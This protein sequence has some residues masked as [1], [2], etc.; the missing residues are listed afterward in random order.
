MLHAKKGFYS[1]AIV[2]VIPVEILRNGAMDFI[3]KGKIRRELLQEA[4]GVC[5]HMFQDVRQSRRMMAKPT[6]LFA[7]VQG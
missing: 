6:F 7:V 2:S 3:D 5:H 1:L 4:L